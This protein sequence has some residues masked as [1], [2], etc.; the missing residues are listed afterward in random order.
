MRGK[1]A[2]VV[3]AA[4]LLACGLG[5][6][7]CSKKE[8]RTV[9]PE[10]FMSPPAR[11]EAGMVAERLDSTGIPGIMEGR[12]TG[13]MV[14]VYFEFDSSSIMGEQLSRIGSNAGF[15]TDNPGL[16]IRVEG[17]CDSRGTKEY[18]LAL[19]E[20][21]AQSAKK[22]L[23]GRGVSLSRMHTI[24]FGEEKP[25]AF[26]ED[27]ESWAQNRRADFVVPNR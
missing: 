15:L 19:G 22:E 26:G 18:N 25:V 12:T 7:G 14:P 1:N 3:G 10:Q 11:S 5:A 23:A 9:L 17:N 16:A 4:V 21:R 24:S 2:L 13:P 27:E 20:R 8:P 6:G